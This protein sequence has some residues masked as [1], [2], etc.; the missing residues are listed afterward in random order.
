MLFFKQ[1]AFIC[2]VRNKYHCAITKFPAYLLPIKE[3]LM[4]RFFFPHSVCVF[5]FFF[6][7][8]T[9]FYFLFFLSMF[10]FTYLFWYLWKFPPVSENFHL[11]PIFFFLFGLFFFSFLIK[12]SPSQLKFPPNLVRAFGAF[13]ASLHNSTKWIRKTIW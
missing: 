6:S 7:S 9:V 1:N 12:I 4:C 13:S 10:L 11:F 5:F 2:C 3:R 8:L